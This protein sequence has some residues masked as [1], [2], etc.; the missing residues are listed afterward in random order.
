MSIIDSYSCGNAPKIPGGVSGE[1]VIPESEEQMIPKP[2]SGVPN[3]R[4]TTYH[5]LK[6]RL[7]NTFETPFEPKENFNIALRFQMYK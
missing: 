5:P 3:S 4:A 6:F 1:R 2:K 7:T